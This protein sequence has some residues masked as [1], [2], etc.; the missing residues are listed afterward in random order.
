VAASSDTT[1][2]NARRFV[3]RGMDFTGISVI[4]ATVGWALGD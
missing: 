4:D 2:A 1:D 3:G